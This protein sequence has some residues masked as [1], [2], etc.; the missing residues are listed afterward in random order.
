MFKSIETRILYGKRRKETQSQMFLIN[1]F[2]LNNNDAPSFVIKM[3]ILR[4]VN[5]EFYCF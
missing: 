2:L 3:N 4:P 1:I 5:Y